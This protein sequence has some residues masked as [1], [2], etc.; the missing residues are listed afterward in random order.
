MPSP[1][2]TADGRLVVVA[3]I[4]CDDLPG[5][6]PGRR[7][8]IAQW[9]LDHED[10]SDCGAAVRRLWVLNRI[11]NGA[12][13]DR[14]SDMLELDGARDPAAGLVPS[15]LPF[16]DVL[17]FPYQ[18]DR[19]ARCADALAAIEYLTN[20]NPA[21]NAALAHADRLRADYVFPLDG[22]IYLPPELLYSVAT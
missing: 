12:L 7:A 13:R 18:P 10:L 14:L 16:T 17:D 2:A 11:R 5:D 8:Q 19:L 20:L 15:R 22:D 1:A 3:H 4:L 9:L 21:R 6:I